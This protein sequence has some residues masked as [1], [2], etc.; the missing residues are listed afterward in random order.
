M[1]LADPACRSDK[2]RS[3]PRTMKTRCSKLIR[4]ASV[5]G[6]AVWAVG[7]RAAA[8][9]VEIPDDRLRDAIRVALGKPTG[10]IHA[11]LRRPEP[12]GSSPPV[13]DAG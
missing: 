13:N 6:L 10:D 11:A 2:Q 1:S 8:Q 3:I 12:G 7:P 4:F 5:L 9:V